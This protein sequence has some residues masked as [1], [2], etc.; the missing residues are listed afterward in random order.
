MGKLW[1]RLHFR[2]NQGGLRVLHSAQARTGLNGK[3]T[4]FKEKS[5]YRVT[6]SSILFCTSCL[7]PF[8][9]TCFNCD[10]RFSWECR[11][12]NTPLSLIWATVDNSSSFYC[13][14]RFFLVVLLIMKLWG[15]RCQ[16]IL[17]HAT[18]ASTLERGKNTIMSVWNCTD[19]TV[20]IRKYLVLL[21]SLE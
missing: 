15:D 17:R 3:I 8:S 2:G 10:F 18:F 12:W 19:V 13:R 11:V 14:G 1:R 9:N 20:N 21:W 6:E 16:E 5:R 4:L 7:L